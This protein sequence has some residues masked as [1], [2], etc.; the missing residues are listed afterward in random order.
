MTSRNHFW[1]VNHIPNSF[2]RKDYDTMIIDIHTHVYPDKIAERAVSKLEKNAGIKARVNGRKD[3]LRE[4]MR[5]A[6]V[7][8]S[9]LLPVA[10]SAK[11]V[12]KINEEA[13]QTNAGADQT[14]LLSFGGIHPDTENYKEVLR[15]ICALGLRGIKLHPDY[16]EAFFDDIRYK[17]IVSEA[18]ELGLYIMVH[19]GEDIG[20]PEPIHCRPQHVLEVL[21]D[22]QSDHLI[23]AHMGGWRLWDEVEQM[24]SDQPVYI[25]T[26]FSENYIQGVG[27]LLDRESFVRIVRKFGAGRVLFGTDSP[28][29]SQKES[30]EWFMETDL[31]AEEKE[32]ILSGNAKKILF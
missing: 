5:E 7:D 28:W 4:S 14:G 24:L 16:Q 9:L 6:G 2:V 10:T 1:L 32:K 23:L 20:L 17:R 8:Y 27:G 30:V 29:S 15:R 11:Q 26:S 21:K 12:D 31:S 18:T 3:G 22:T 25:D 13:G 19:A